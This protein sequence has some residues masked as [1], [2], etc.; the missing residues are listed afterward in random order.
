MRIEVLWG[1]HALL[2]R[3]PCVHINAI[4]ITFSSDGN[5]SY[6]TQQVT[7]RVLASVLSFSFISICS[8]ISQS[9]GE[10]GVSSTHIK[11]GEAF[12]RQ[13]CF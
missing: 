4:V 13:D 10:R 11:V 8:P 7:F 6:Q 9:I 1:N 2:E 3:R 12:S 5:E